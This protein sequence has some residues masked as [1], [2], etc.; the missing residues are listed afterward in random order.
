MASW[1]S[2]GP[3]CVVEMCAIGGKT[4]SCRT[5]T[6]WQGPKNSARLDKSAARG[7]RTAA[8]RAPGDRHVAPSV[9]SGQTYPVIRPQVVN[10]LVERRRPEIFANELDNLERVGKARLGEREPETTVGGTL[11]SVLS[12]TKYIRATCSAAKNAPFCQV[13]ADSEAHAL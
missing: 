10:L 6:P 1:T 9:R 12:Q 7:V 5:K 3:P 4:A 2:V 13:A 8:E 11:V